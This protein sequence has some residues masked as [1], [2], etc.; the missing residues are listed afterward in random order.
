MS[1]LDK[2]KGSAV[3]RRVS[4]LDN[5][6]LQQQV[7]SLTSTVNNIQSS[8]TTQL[9]TI[10]NTTNS[11]V[12][13]V[14]SINANLI[15]TSSI[16]NG[17][18]DTLGFGIPMFV[19]DFLGQSTETGE[20]G[21]HGWSFIRGSI[22]ASA[23][24]ANH[25]GIIIRRSSTVANE[26]SSLYLG[27]STSTNLFLWSQFNT[28]VFIVDA[29]SATNDYNYRLGLWSGDVTNGAPTTAV[30]FERLAANSF[31]TPVVRS[32]GSVNTPGT[33]FTHDTNW[34][35]YRITKI[36]ETEILFQVDDTYQYVESVVSLNGAQEMGIAV[37]LTPTT[38]TARDLKI[39]F[40]SLLLQPQKR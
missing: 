37:Q 12:N 21:V 29:V 11:L 40:I 34:H 6:Q 35:K 30:Y 3:S 38:T 26:N 33:T 39:D 9:T 15:A 19:D 23:P 31:I 24:E 22:V 10:T 4:N 2:R 17:L 14:S 8:V 1:D 27:A 18:S 13:R 36:S 28:A 20:T 5:E 25:P 16:V 32:L 7:N